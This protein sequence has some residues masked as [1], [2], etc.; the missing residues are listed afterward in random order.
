MGTPPENDSFLYAKDTPKIKVQR[1][2]GTRRHHAPLQ[3]SKHHRL[4]CGHFAP[5]EMDGVAHATGLIRDCGIT[6]RETINVIAS[7]HKTVLVFKH[8]SCIGHM[9]YLK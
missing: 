6:V 1:R 8:F 5:F 3:G 7:Q 2:H 9:P 4:I